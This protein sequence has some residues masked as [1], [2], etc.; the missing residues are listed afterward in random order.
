MPAN[1]ENREKTR[2]PARAAASGSAV[3]N[4]SAK[5]IA[6]GFVMP[7]NPRRPGRAKRRAMLVSALL[8]VG[9]PTLLAAVYYAFFASDQYA[10]SGHFVVRHRSE[11]PAALSSLSIL[12]LGTAATSSTPDTMVVNDYMI[13]MQMIKDLAD[14]LDLRT[15]YDTPKADW[16]ARLKPALGEDTVSDEQLLKYWQR[17]A[18]VHFDSTTGLSTFEVRGFAAE[19]AKKIADQVFALG[20]ALVNRISTRAQ[21]DAL[22]LARQ[23]VEAYRQRAMDSLDD[24]QAFQERAKQVDPEGFAQARTQIQTGV[25]QELT[26]LQ[27]QLDVLRKNLPEDAPGI[28]QVKDRLASMEKQLAAERTRSTVSANGESAAQILNEF[29]KL[30]LENEFATQ[31]YMSSLASLESA[32]VEAIRQNLYLETFVRP[33]VPQVAEY[34]HALLNTLLVLV[35][36]FLVWAIGGLLV[37]AAREHW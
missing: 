36:S 26:Q 22:S 19:D 1:K 27:A 9:L 2:E 30:R 12:G 5:T 8:V 20:E 13:S 33:H 23:E 21:E 4:K 37:S 7:R 16:L 6:P 25:E 17:M 15:I 10:A 14:H 3:E 28:T 34:P 32:R 31:A 24:M 11:N 18:L 29:A 35:V